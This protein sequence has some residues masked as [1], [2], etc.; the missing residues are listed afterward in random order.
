MPIKVKDKNWQGG[1]VRRR[2]EGKEG[3]KGRKMNE[4]AER[5]WITGGRRAVK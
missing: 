3:E 5:K 2:D 1:E 4:K